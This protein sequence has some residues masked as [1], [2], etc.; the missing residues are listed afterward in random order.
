MKLL[1]SNLKGN[2]INNNAG[3]IKHL[4]NILKFPSLNLEY[5]ELSLY[6]N[7]IGEKI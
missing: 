6:G 7:D 1:I 4:K 2:E 5:F 3:T